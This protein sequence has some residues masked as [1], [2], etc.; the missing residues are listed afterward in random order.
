M[1]ISFF[2]SVMGG[3]CDGFLAWGISYSA[4]TP[5]PEGGAGSEVC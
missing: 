4:M 5:P 3:D 2:L 1:V